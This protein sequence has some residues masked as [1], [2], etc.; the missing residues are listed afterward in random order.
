MPANPTFPW[1][2]R[3]SNLR[4][5]ACEAWRSRG[6]QPTK[7]L[8]VR[9]NAATVS[10]GVRPDTA[11]Y[12]WGSAQ[13]MA[14]RPAPLRHR[15][16]LGCAGDDRARNRCACASCIAVG[17]RVGS[18]GRADRPSAQ[19]RGGC[20]RCSLLAGR[21]ATGMMH[22]PALEESVHAGSGAASAIAG[23]LVESF[24]YPAPA[25]RGCALHFG[26]RACALAARST[27]RNI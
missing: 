9:Q 12:G 16:A 6:T 8:Q 7:C 5:L 21:R 18:D 3:V 17:V 1:A 19:S 13:R 24:A 10:A 26:T 2:R 4:A 11:R 23:L 27:A 15:E 22:R 25:E 14:Q 20:H